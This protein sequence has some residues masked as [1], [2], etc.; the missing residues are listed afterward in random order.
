[1]L[2]SAAMCEADGP[3]TQD[4]RTA[5][6]HLAT[7]LG[8]GE[9][10]ASSEL[11][12]VDR[13]KLRSELVKAKGDRSFSRHLFVAAYLVGMGDG[14]LMDSERA[15]LEDCAKA[16]ALEPQLCAELEGDLHGILYEELLETTYHHG[17]HTDLTSRERSILSAAA[18]LLGLTPDAAQVIENAFLVRL[19]IGGMAAY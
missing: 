12:S 14:V 15:F 19:Q 4:E 7:F 2:T 5:L 13:A 1:M 6:E 10:S 3:S 8:V 16:V 11:R 18:K 9:L 17:Q